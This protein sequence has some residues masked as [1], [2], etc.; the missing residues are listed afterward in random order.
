MAQILDRVSETLVA[1]I[2]GSD[3]DQIDAAKQKAEAH[4]AKRTTAALG[5]PVNK[6]QQW[7]SDPNPSAVASNVQK[8]MQDILARK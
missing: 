1:L 7:L 8:V 5:D 4:A 2:S 3:K 6:L